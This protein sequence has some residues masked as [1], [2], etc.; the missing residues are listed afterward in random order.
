MATFQNHSIR[1]GGS[2]YEFWGRQEHLFSNF[3]VPKIIIFYY[4]YIKGSIPRSQFFITCL[5]NSRGE[6]D[7]MKTILP[8]D[9]EL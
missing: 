4:R 2:T 8:Y 6:N 7:S 5:E 9:F 1:I 3:K